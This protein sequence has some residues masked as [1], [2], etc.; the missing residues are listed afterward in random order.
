MTN[1][2]NVG[3]KLLLPVTFNGYMGPKFNSLRSAWLDV[4][5][6]TFQVYPP[7]VT[8]LIPADRITELEAEVASLK[9]ALYMTIDPFAPGTELAMELLGD[10]QPW[11][12]IN[13]MRRN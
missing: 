12:T 4:G 11:E 1:N 2:L 6:R 7:D 9:Y 13:Q 3:D 5:G 10:Y 8:T